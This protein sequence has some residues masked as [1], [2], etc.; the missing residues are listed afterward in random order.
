MISASFP[1]AVTLN[2]VVVSC[3]CP[4]W[5]FRRRVTAIEN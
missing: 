3:G 2:Q 1:Q 4:L 5:S